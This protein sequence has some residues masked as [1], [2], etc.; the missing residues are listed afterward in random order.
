MVSHKRDYCTVSWDHVAADT[1]VFTNYNV[2][3][4]V[5]QDGGTI[6]EMTRR[7]QKVGIHFQGLILAHF[8]MLRYKKYSTW[9]G[10]VPLA[11]SLQLLF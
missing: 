7:L 3:Q 6:T 1:T 5:L 2:R 10:I 9:P 4:A 11:Q 8:A